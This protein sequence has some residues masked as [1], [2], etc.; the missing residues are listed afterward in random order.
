MAFV[1]LVICVVGIYASF[2]SWA[3][4]QERLSTTPY[5]DP[6]GG[7]PKYF[8]SVIFLNTVQS[9][10]SATAALLY[11]L[12]KKKSS[13]SILQ[14]LGLTNPTPS[15][16]EKSSKPLKSSKLVTK[17]QNRLALLGCCL[18]CAI[19]NSLGSPFGYASLKHIDYPTMILG[20]SCKLV[21]VMIMNIILYRRKFAVHKYIVVGMV[22]IGISLF[23]LFAN[24]GSKASK[25]PQQSS[26]FGLSLLLVNLLID[27]ATNSTQ[28]E[29]FSRFTISGSQLMF[30][31]NALATIITLAVLQAPIPTAISSFFGTS[32]SSGNEFTAAIEF[33]KS[34]PKVLQDILLFSSAGAIGQLF[35]FET[36][37]H[38]GSLTLVTITVTRK[39][40]TML[41]SVFIFNHQLSFGQWGGI[42]IV[43]LAIGLEAY[44]K[45]SGH[46]QAK[47]I[48]NEK[49]K[50]KMKEL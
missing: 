13:Q 35:I 1:R 36:L 42:A 21:P 40:F 22:T 46:G 19:L 20:K 7:S 3:L 44:V 14:V 24:H 12:L 27:G 23:M 8:K 48:I 25:G 41:L 49:Q 26:L 30:I 39:L 45:M 38:F 18:Q 50:S 32:N 5:E 28:D 9:G 10:F 16:P 47:S 31:M 11:L 17:D 2:L 4:I 43:F 6:S 15:K 34:S 33:I 37:S 29:I